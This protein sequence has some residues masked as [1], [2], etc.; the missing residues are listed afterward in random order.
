MPS[1]RV[2]VITPV[3]SDIA[4]GTAAFGTMSPI[5]DRRTGVSK[6]DAKPETADNA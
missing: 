6:A 2:D 3:F 4:L 1:T 5:I